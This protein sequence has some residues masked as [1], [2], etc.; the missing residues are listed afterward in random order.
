[1]AFFVYNNIKNVGGTMENIISSFGNNNERS[2]INPTRIKVIGVGG[3]GGNAVNRMVKAKLAGVEF[4]QMNTDLQVLTFSE[5]QNKLQLGTSTTKGLG[6]GG[7]PT[8]GEKAALE[9]KEDITRALEGADMV[10]ITAGM[11]GGTGTGAAPIVAQIAKDLGI[12]TIAFVTKPFCWEGKKRM[13]QA[14]AGIEKLKKYTDSILVVP[15]DKLLQVVERQMGLREAFCVTDEVLYRG[16]Q[17]ISDII[18]IPGM[19]NIDFA[20]VRKVVK[21]SGTAL[22]GIG[23]AQGEGRAI[24]AAEMAINSQLLESS[25]DGARGIIVNITGSSNMTLYEITDATNIINNVVRDDADVIIG[26][27]INEAF[28]N[29]IQIT[30]IA[31]GFAEKPN[32][33][34]I[35]TPQLS[36]AEY[37]QGKTTTSS[38]NDLS[39]PK[40]PS[41][42]LDVPD[43]LKR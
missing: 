31:T 26:T 18:T 41:M 1:L 37:F 39:F 33:S 22:M 4:W 32:Q 14:E 38:S 8:T 23:R 43:F 42:S 40:M 11:G 25:I 7:D 35:N 19:I 16:I 34:S 10:F 2:N 12:L 30:V 9:A 5:V 24:K 29:E 20:D 17:G 36:A 28:Q 13:S 21:D 3:G 15:N 27:A 6:S